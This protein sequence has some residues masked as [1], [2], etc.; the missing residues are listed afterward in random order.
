MLVDYLF[1]DELSHLAGGHPQKLA[2]DILVIRAYDRGSL[3]TL[4]GV[5]DNFREPQDNLFTHDGCSTSTA[6]HAL[7][8]GSLNISW[9]LKEAWQHSN[10]LQHLGHLVMSIVDRPLCDQPV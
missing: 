1:I 7:E 6:I 3:M 9:L 8:V 2:E 5:S 4:A 10:L